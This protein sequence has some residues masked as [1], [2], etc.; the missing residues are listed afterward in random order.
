MS[1]SNSASDSVSAIERRAASAG[2]AV[3]VDVLETVAAIVGH[4]DAQAARLDELPLAM[5][6]PAAVFDPRWP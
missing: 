2:V 6:P 3:S 1:P 4:V 5:T